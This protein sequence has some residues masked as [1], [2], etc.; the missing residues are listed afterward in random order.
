MAKTKPGKTPIRMFPDLHRIEDFVQNEHPIHHP[1]TKIYEDYWET[2]EKKCVE[3]MWGFDGDPDDVQPSQGFRY[4]P[5]FLYFYINM[6]NILDVDEANKSRKLIHPLLR[7]V[8]WLMSYG[9]LICRGFSGFIDD[10]HFT[11]H[12]R[13]E[14]FDPL[15]DSGSDLPPSCFKSDGTPKEYKN[16]QEY[17]YTTHAEPLGNPLYLNDAKNS[18]ILGSRGFGKD[19]H[20]DTLVWTPSGPQSIKETYVGDQIYGR[21]GNLTTVISRKDY[22]DQLQYK[23]TLKDER[24]VICGGGHLWTVWDSK[25]RKKTLET[26]EMIDVDL[27]IP[28]NECIKFKSKKDIKVEGMYNLGFAWGSTLGNEKKKIPEGILL[29]SRKHRMA[30]VEGVMDVRGHVTRRGICQ[31]RADHRENLK[32]FSTILRSLGFKIRPIKKDYYNQYSYWSIGFIPYT[33]VFRNLDKKFAQKLEPSVKQQIM[34]KKVKISSIEPL[35]IMPSVCLGVDNEDKLFVVN[36]FVVTHNSFFCA[37]AVIA[38]EFLF[39]GHKVFNDDYLIKPNTVEIFLGSALS[40]KS[41]QLVQMVQ[42]GFNNLPGAYGEGDDYIPSPF[43]KNCSGVLTPNNKQNPYRHKYKERQGG[44]WV[45]KGSRSAIYHG[46]YTTENPQAA[47]GGR[48]TVMVIEEVGLVPNVLGV[49]GANETTMTAGTL[50]FGSSFFIGTGGNMEKILESKI[51]FTDPK[52]YDIIP[53]KDSFEHRSKPIGLFMPAYYAL[54]QYKNELGNTDLPG[55]FKFLEDIRKE[56]RKSSTSIA[57]NEEMMARPLIP[58]EMFLSKEGTVFPVEL[59]RE[60]LTKIEI[61]DLWRARASVGFLD[62]I[63]NSKKHVKWREDLS[64]S[65]TLPIVT[66]NLDPYQGRIDGDIVIYEHPPDNI[67]A[68]SYTRSLYKIVYDPVKDDH[69]GTSLSSILVYKG[70]SDSS[71]EGGLQDAIVA[72][73]VGRLD[74]VNDM[75][76]IAIKL[77]LY[78]NAKV[79]VENNIPDFIRYCRKSGYWQILQP[80][81]YLAISKVIK[82]PSRKYEVGITMSQQLN[83]H[84]EQLLR[85]WLLEPWNRGHPEEDGRVNVHKLFSTRILEELTSY[86]R[87]GNFDCVSA[88]KLLAV[89]L[90]QESEEPIVRE[91]QDN[92]HQEFKDYIKGLRRGRRQQALKQTYY[93]F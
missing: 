3:G 25:G 84:S 91:R 27:R 11:C 79:M 34:S 8:E 32:E 20:E 13:M 69:M 36:D 55:A 73:Y 9:W 6:W 5:G 76:D 53:Y 57:I 56:K 33:P 30:F 50:K 71:W 77:S 81:P 4:M 22:T 19:L 51:M 2:Q 70:F 14:N 85:Q 46:I 86:N 52:S 47:V 82:N 21:D 12:R 7:D 28:V 10:E 41:S 68:P 31:L 58:S 45:E 75:H 88:L 80:S 44:N 61:E 18:F 37:G 78:Y 17:L 49:H 90:S 60:R 63:D 42:L 93:G 72:E 1:D 74:K 59:L 39:D 66:Y 64:R 15:M 62:Y 83:T 38:H 54:N 92:R 16:A 48:Y 89:W 23:V 87:D 43:F 65:Q 35:E 67:P 26:R 29:R 40:D 24:E